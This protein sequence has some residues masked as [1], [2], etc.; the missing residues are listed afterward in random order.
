MKK[1]KH[2]FVFVLAI[3]LLGIVSSVRWRETSYHLR[4]ISSWLAKYGDGPAN[5]KPSPE[6]DH[7]LRQMGSNAVPYLL[8]LIHS[9]DSYSYHTF[10]VKENQ[11]GMY[12]I[13]TPRASTVWGHIT[14]WSVNMRS[15]FQ[16]VT[17]PASW[18][19][20]KAYLAF[21]ALGSEGDSAIPD[22]I[23]LAHDPGANSSPGNP[24]EVAPISFWKDRNNIRRFAAQS[25][26][27]LPDGSPVIPIG[28][29]F[30]GGGRWETPFLSDGEI[31]AWSL[32]AIGAESVPPLM[33]MLTNSND[34]IRCRAAIALGMMGQP[35]EPAVP[36]LINMLQDPDRN[37][38]QE[39]ADA[40]G[41]IGQQTDLVI[42]ALIKTFDDK[43]VEAVAIKSLGA[44]G[45]RAT[46]AIPA[47]LALFQAENNSV[48]QEK[49]FAEKEHNSGLLMSPWL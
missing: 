40:L 26:T 19:H 44:L 32:A 17:A 5:Y 37:T 45:E 7:A 22:L 30:V 21:Q 11:R 42:P 8:K 14:A 39:A 4:P 48:D 1:H 47:L 38:R 9:T 49:D 43:E 16:K 15:R 23:K 3:A 24:G 6:T 25:S 10:V 41:C 20:W 29:A 2:I 36:A 35:G 46:N 27:Y 13:W 31:A 34:H 33:E 18:D 12:P 28:Y